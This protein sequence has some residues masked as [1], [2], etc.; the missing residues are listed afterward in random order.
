[1]QIINSL[2]EDNNLFFCNILLH[3]IKIGWDNIFCRIME[4]FKVLNDRKMAS[5]RDIIDLTYY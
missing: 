2:Y 1:M 5:E 3:A 4:L